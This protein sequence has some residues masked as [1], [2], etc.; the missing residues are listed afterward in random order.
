MDTNSFGSTLEDEFFRREDQR[1]LARLREQRE[2][3]TARETLS[4][5]TGITNP[6]VLDKLMAL[7][8]QPEIIAALRIVPLVEVAWADGTLDDKERTA[9]LS[10]AQEADIPLASAAYA[11]LEAWLARKPEPHVLNAWTTLVQGMSESLP[12]AE[13]KKL[14]AWLMDRARQV[15]GASGGMLGLGSKVSKQEAAVLEKLEKAFAR[16]TA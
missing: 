3:A 13:V 1:L 9:I 16:P 11:L 14:E 8:I 2:T 12:A 7:K 10:G 4:Q 6:A 15:A 5:A